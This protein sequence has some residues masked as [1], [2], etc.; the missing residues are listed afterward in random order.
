VEDLDMTRLTLA[1]A[2]WISFVSAIPASLTPRTESPLA[3]RKALPALA[4]G[5]S[6]VQAVKLSASVSEQAWGE[7]PFV[8]T[9]GTEILLNGKPCSYEEIPGHASIVRMEVAADKKTVL[10]IHFRTRK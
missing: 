9:S 10:K 1:L 3:A 2:A 7:T 4:K 6:Q 5:V 8:L